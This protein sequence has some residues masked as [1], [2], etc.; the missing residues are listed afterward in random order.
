MLHLGLVGRETL[1]EFKKSITGVLCKRKRSLPVGS[2]VYYSPA[3]AVPAA[4]VRYLSE[5]LRNHC[6][7]GQWGEVS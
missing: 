5:T 1:K 2:V 4:L 7:T 6:R 3:N